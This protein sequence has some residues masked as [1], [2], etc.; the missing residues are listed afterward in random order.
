MTRVHVR[1]VTAT[2]AKNECMILLNALT[3]GLAS[4][5]AYSIVLLRMTFMAYPHRSLEKAQRPCGASEAFSAFS[6][7]HLVD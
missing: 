1:Q 2:A 6:P 5:G 3:F 7:A 4:L